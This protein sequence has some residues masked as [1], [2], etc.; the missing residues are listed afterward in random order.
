VLLD[1]HIPDC[2]NLI[3]AGK[4]RGLMITSVVPK[5]SNG[6]KLVEYYSTANALLDVGMHQVYHPPMGSKFDIV[7]CTAMLKTIED[8]LINAPE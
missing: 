4:K 1:P 2:I 3:E 6:S 8:E 7:E 5:P